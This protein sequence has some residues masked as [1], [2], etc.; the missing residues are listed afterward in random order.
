MQGSRHPH[1]L[2]LCRCHIHH[3][4]VGQQV[5]GGQVVGV[6]AIQGAEEVGWDVAEMQRGA[7]DDLFALQAADVED[8]FKAGRVSGLPIDEQRGVQCF[9]GLLVT[10]AYLRFENIGTQRLV[11][12]FAEDAVAIRV[13]IGQDFLEI[14]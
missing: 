10:D 13:A 5:G 7:D 8:V 3:R 4:Q 2:R 6:A 1:S 11:G 9:H 12:H 14:R